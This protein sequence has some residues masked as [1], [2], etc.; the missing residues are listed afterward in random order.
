MLPKCRLT[1]FLE[2]GQC[3]PLGERGTESEEPL[4]RGA[5]RAPREGTKSPKG[6]TPPYM[7]KKFVKNDLGKPSKIKIKKSMEF[8]ILFKTHPPHL[9]SMEKNIN[10][11]V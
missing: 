6:G 4:G 1:P 8:S 10:N 2:E 9:P 11:M 7:K 5:P 3:Y